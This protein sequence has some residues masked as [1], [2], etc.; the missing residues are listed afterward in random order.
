[1]TKSITIRKNGSITIP[2]EI[3]KRYQL[4]ENDLL[5]LTDIGDC[6]VK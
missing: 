5:T 2:I 3:R 1:M 6:P 4:N